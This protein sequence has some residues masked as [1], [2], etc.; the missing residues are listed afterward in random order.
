VV[1]TRVV[2][3]DALQ[4]PWQGSQNRPANLLTLVDRYA[5]S[6]RVRQIHRIR[7]GLDRSTIALL[8]GSVFD[9][10][11]TERVVSGRLFGTSVT[12]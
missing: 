3:A 6:A 12:A 1:A 5:M 4:P 11:V 8:V 7:G 9:I 2:K 10:E